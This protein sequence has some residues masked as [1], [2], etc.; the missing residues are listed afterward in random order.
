MIVNLI[1]KNFHINK[2]VMETKYLRLRNNVGVIENSLA[3]SK[4][5]YEV[6]DFIESTK[7]YKS[8]DFDIQSLLEI[9]AFDMMKPTFVSTMSNMDFADKFQNF[10]PQPLEK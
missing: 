7:G 3:K 5:S 4:S 10:N 2:Y 9:G 6:C 1:N 8:S